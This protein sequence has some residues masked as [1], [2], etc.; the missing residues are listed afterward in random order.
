MDVM[1]K[2]QM[3]AMLVML[4]LLQGSVYAAEDVNFDGQTSSKSFF[5]VNEDGNVEYNNITVS[6]STITGQ[7]CGAIDIRHG[8][9]SKQTFTANEL[10]VNNLK[11]STNKLEQYAVTF[12]PYNNS[13]DSNPYTVNKITVNGVKFTDMDNE[14]G[15]GTSGGGLYL[16]N[17]NFSEPIESISIK[18][19]ENNNSQGNYY[20]IK[21]LNGSLVVSE[22]VIDGVTAEKGTAYGLSNQGNALSVGSLTISSITGDDAYGIQVSSGDTKLDILNSA[23]NLIKVEKITANNLA[24][25]VWSG[26]DSWNTK[27]LEVNGVTSSEGSAYGVNLRNGTADY[28]TSNNITGHKEA[29]GVNIGDG[30]RSNGLLNSKQINVDGVYLD[31]KAQEGKIYGVT[32]TYSKQKKSVDEIYITNVKSENASE[33]YGFFNEHSIWKGDI[34]SIDGV[35]ASA[36]GTAIGIGTQATLNPKSLSYADNSLEYSYLSAKNISG[37]EAIG[38]KHYAN[39]GP[40]NI[41][42]NHIYIANIMGQ[43]SAIGIL[44]EQTTSG[45]ASLSISLSD[46]SEFENNGI[47]CVENVSAEKGTA[48]GILNKGTLN[49]LEDIVNGVHGTTEAVGFEAAGDV[50]ASSISVNDVD[51]TQGKAYGIHFNKASLS[52]PDD[53]LIKLTATN[54]DAK[55][56][57]AKGIYFEG[58]NTSI[59]KTSSMNVDTVTSDTDRAIG[60]HFNNIGSQIDVENSEAIIVNN[61]SGQ[62]NTM[63]FLSDG[64]NNNTITT[65]TFQ[66]TNITGTSKT[67]G[68]N[69]NGDLNVTG[70]FLQDD[71]FEGLYIDNVKGTSSATGL[72]TAKDSHLNVGR[73]SIGNISATDAFSNV[74]GLETGALTNVFNGIVYVYKISGN[75]SIGGI[76]QSNANGTANYKDSV[77]VSDVTSENTTLGD[78]YGLEIANETTFE[79]DL[80]VDSITSG[81]NAYGINAKSTSSISAV[82][83]NITN[84]KGKTA[85]GI[86]AAGTSDKAFSVSNL[87]YVS[88]IEGSDTAV[89]LAVESGEADFAAVNISDVS[90]VNGR[91]ALVSAKEGADVSIGSGLITHE[92]FENSYNPSYTGNYTGNA[93]SVKNNIKSIALRSV[94][95]S[96]ITL[97]S[98]TSTFAADD[99]PVDGVFTVVGDI[100]AGRGAVD[101]EAGSIEINGKNGTRICGDVYA[102]NY[103]TINI[104][105]DGEKSVLEGQVD[106]YH[107][108]AG[109]KEGEVFHNSAFVDSEGNPLDVAYAGNATL[110]INDGAH[111]IARGQSFVDTVT[112]N[113]GTVDMSKNENSSVTVN[114]LSGNGTVKMRLNTGDRDQSDMLYVTGSLEGNYELQIAGDEFDI[115]EITED[116]PL[117]F[118]TVKGDVNTENL[119]ARAVDAG[120][121]NN[122]YTITKENFAVGDDENVIY[123]NSGVEA[124]GDHAADY[125]PGNDYIESTF[126]AADTNLLIGG[127]SS[128]TVS[129]AGKT[130]INM[131]RANYSNAIYMDRL[132]KRMGE[133][134]YINPEEEQGMWVRLRHDRIGKTDAFRSQNT[135]YEMGYDVKQDCGNG[136]RR[137]G[138]AID[139]MD[140]KT[141]Y[142]NVAG[143][144]DIKRYGLWLY[145]TWTGNKGHYTDF[146]AKWGHLEN[147]FEI[148]NS[149]GKVNGDYSNN[150]F[151]VSA[152][153]GKKN[154]M[155]SGWYFEPQA[156]LQLARVT[157][158]DYVTSQNTRVSLDGINSLIGRA[159]FRLG[160]DLDE[161]STVYVKADLLHEFLG[162]Q[163]IIAYDITTNGVYRETFENKGTWYD[164]GFGFATALGK[165]SYA[166][167]DFEKS[168]G[169]DND[170]TY[171]VNAGVQWTF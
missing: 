36:N 155:S 103:G 72:F 2:K 84:V 159:G 124:G 112:L 89:A 94:G 136:E 17:T 129:D 127:V 137:I 150:V 40:S 138:M 160:R 146:V 82:T 29:Y 76:N 143:D 90:S 9:N 106:D 37:G 139:Y 151:S 59:G 153:Y 166:F 111:W 3:L 134:R 32:N 86:L 156:Q 168:F 163:T 123:N 46:N 14:G 1:K 95:G 11:F 104:T 171:Q 7:A 25:G 169:N 148:Y 16:S 21:L 18:N 88:G 118:A 61:V 81:N 63:G 110:N 24:Y 51:T 23:E 69:V 167:M 31:N 67:Y 133:T 101:A 92:D 114:D 130:I 43:D 66:V 42:S 12:A 87:A 132:N 120:F 27:T 73:V 147:D 164:V 105:L 154:D 121:F 55:G 149:L 44:N 140:G 165:N 79:K 15:I 13:S 49:G 52:L 83:T 78:A 158:A 98:N 91:I 116:N 145:D 30:S 57:E 80:N 119:K 41:A 70:N 100:V 93:D 126:D 8:N 26:S 56:G 125:K 170:E 28:I 135:M 20:G 45:E 34:A 53:G 122:D 162:D 50:E 96:K 161:N 128:Q 38:L 19:I 65:K 99:T 54:I 4:S 108:L 10:T 117:R 64:A 22:A 85:I 157:G 48:Y 142:R 47:V 39:Q 6:N 113:G 77:Y 33:A 71:S 35:V 97:G 62:S 68:I 115:N 152:E 109:D 144:G 75:Y 107:E 58:R 60:I 141:E 102:G 74:K 131:S 5:S